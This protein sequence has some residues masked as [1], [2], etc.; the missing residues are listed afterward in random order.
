LSAEG[1]SDAYIYPLTPESPEWAQLQTG[2]EMYAA[3]LIPS[4]QLKD[5]CTHGILDSWLTYPLLLN[6]F[7]WPTPQKGIDAVKEQFNGLME[8]YRRPNAGLSAFNKYKA[9]DPSSYDPSWS[10]V[11]KGRFAILIAV[12]ELTISQEAV[13]RTLSSAERKELVK[14]A[15]KKRTL[16]QMILCMS[17]SLMP[18]TFSSWGGL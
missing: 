3:C 8:F 18:S 13:L 10:S 11:E 1:K 12:I 15:L 2:E 5:M 14:E 7:A 17:R 4:G 16:R 9:L 6:V